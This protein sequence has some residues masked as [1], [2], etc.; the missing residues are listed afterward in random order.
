LQK[1]TFSDYLRLHFVVLVWGFTAILGKLISIPAVE[2]VLWRT[3]LA[4]SLLACLLLWQRKTFRIGKDQL[5]VFLTGM[6]IAG[7]WLLFFA[8]ARVANVSACLVGMATSTLW[9]SL[10]EPVIYRRKFSGLEIFLS[11]CVFA[12]LG[13]V[14]K[15]ESRYAVG[16]LMGVA[17]ALL[18]SFF[19]IFNSRFVKRHDPFVISFYEMLGAFCGTVLFLPLY[20]R[21]FA[22]SQ[23]LQ[24]T[25]NLSDWLYISLLVGVCTVY[26]FSEGVRLLRKFTP[27]VMN[28]T[29]NL[30]PVYGIVMA[31]FIF[32]NS[33]QMTPGFY[34]GAAVV[35]VAVLAY[36]VLQSV[37]S[38]KIPAK[39]E[40]EPEKAM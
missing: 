9:T 33:E 6:I 23:S 30:E 12:G 4:F 22:E 17:S 39:V 25:P 14:F 15:T 16:L 34:A 21:F 36:P 35:L 20:L 38:P 2:L 37:F 28:L 8:A 11:L 7:H 10:L 31:Y 1:L 3:C 18:A 27:F 13:L 29:V 32:G 26:A 24:L 40:S 19:S 5:P